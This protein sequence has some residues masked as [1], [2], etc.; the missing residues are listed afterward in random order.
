M[1]YVQEFRMW[2]IILMK[3]KMCTMKYCGVIKTEG[4]NT[5]GVKN[6]MIRKRV[7]VAS[8]NVRSEA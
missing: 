3:N 1:R 8:V 5:K 2:L 4:A 6:V 7:D